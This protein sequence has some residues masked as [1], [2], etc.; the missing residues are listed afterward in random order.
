[1]RIVM[2][3]PPGSGKGTQGVQVAT[4]YGIP[5]ISSGAVLRAGAGPELLSQMAAGEL[6]DDETIAGLIWARLGEPDA[7]TGF[8]LDGFPR[9]VEQAGALDTFLQERGDRLDAVV[10]L[11][12]PREELQQRML[13]RAETEQRP[14]DNPTTIARRL[15][16]YENETAPLIELYAGKGV[17]R[18]V[19]GAGDP[20][21]IAARLSSALESGPATPDSR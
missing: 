13:A 4:S 21:E 6:I 11:E 18:R 9:D 1:V 10:L 8:V 16:V 5:H 12:A 3:G 7:A 20:V 17:L 14:D 19:D 15:D 2:M